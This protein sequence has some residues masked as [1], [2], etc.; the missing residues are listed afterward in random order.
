MALI[1]NGPPHFI[2]PFREDTG[3]EGPLYTDPSRK[4]Y[5]LL[6]F[7]RGMMYMGGL[8]SM[9]ETLRAVTT[10]HA[11]LKVEGDTLQQGGVVVIGPDND[12]LFLYRNEETGDHAPM[13]DVLEAYTS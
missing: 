10:G 11:V 9:K 13:E 5:R 3:Y 7:K 12:V 4:S 2:G 1:S 8:K 6:G